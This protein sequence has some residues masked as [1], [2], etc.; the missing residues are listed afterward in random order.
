MRVTFSAHRIT[1]TNLIAGIFPV[2][3]FD[4]ADFTFLSGAGIGAVAIDPSSSALFA[5][6]SVLTSGRNNIRIDLSGTCEFCVGGESI[7]LNVAA[8]PEPAPAA[9][10]GGGMLVGALAAARRRRTA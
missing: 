2:E 4:G 6:G 3:D 10:L 9:L 1:L 5:P 7:V 8:V